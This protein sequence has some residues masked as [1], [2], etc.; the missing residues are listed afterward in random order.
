MIYKIFRQNEWLNLK[1]EG[2][3]LGA[4]IDIQDGYIHFSTGSQVAETAEK[5]FKGIDNLFVAAID[6]SLIT[7]KLAWEPARN[8]KLFPHLYRELKLSEI[9]WCE[10]LP[11]KNGKH[12]LPAQIK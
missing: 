8:N 6:E 12:I 10:K 9:I 3:T 5:Y 11:L 4:P 7:D 2:A 1:N